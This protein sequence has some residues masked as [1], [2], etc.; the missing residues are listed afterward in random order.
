M[1]FWAITCYRVPWTVK[2]SLWHFIGTSGLLPWKDRAFPSLQ[3]LVHTLAGKPAGPDGSTANRFFL[4]DS[5]PGRCP[6]LKADAAAPWAAAEMQQI[7]RMLAVIRT[8]KH[9]ILACVIQ[10]LRH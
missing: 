4:P 8:D 10:S 3:Y 9:N 5:H 1:T 2:I 7:W 6:L